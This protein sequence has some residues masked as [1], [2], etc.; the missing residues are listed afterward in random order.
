MTVLTAENSCDCNLPMQR[1]A[2]S[3]TTKQ[4]L[5]Q[6]CTHLI[7]GENIKIYD[8]KLYDP[9]M[10][11][12]H[13]SHESMYML[14]TW[15]FDGLGKL[16]EDGAAKHGSQEHVEHTPEEEEFTDAAVHL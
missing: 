14:V 6:A 13:H 5:T 1:I 10:H 16:T 12:A 15:V 7:L 8:E 11:V 2:V 9:I 3:K 4:G